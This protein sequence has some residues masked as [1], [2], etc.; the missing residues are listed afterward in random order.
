[1]AAPLAAAMCLY[2]LGPAYERR[3]AS[4]MGVGAIAT[5]GYATR[6]TQAVQPLLIS[7]VALSGFALLARLVPKGDRDGIRNALQ[8]SCG[9]LFFASVPL[10]ALLAGF[11][12]PVIGLIFERGAFTRADTDAVAPLFALYALGLPAGAVGTVVGQAYY[13]F[14]NTR[15]PILAGLLD[16]A[17]FAALATWLAPRL[18]LVALPI[19]F[20]ISFHVTALL[21]ARL[22]DRE[23]G[24]P[25]L[26]LLTRPL[27][28]AAIASVIALGAALL[29][30]HFVATSYLGSVLCLPAGGALYL[31]IQHFIFRSPET[32]RLMQGLRGRRS[33]RSEGP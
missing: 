21:I 23:T 13:A 31:S 32:A 9:A 15:V 4:D 14:Q 29:L 30:E 8:K 25:V 6:L 28:R 10:A 24:F 20:L 2:K 22:L 18:G 27:A 11:A 5:L 7:G 33:T 16:I 12:E 1:M 19:A 17:L 26:P 3:L